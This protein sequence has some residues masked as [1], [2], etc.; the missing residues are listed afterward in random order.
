MDSRMGAFVTLRSGGALRGCI[1]SFTPA[2]TLSETVVRMAAAAAVED[3][4]FPPVTAREVPVVTIEISVL[5]PMTPCPAGDVVAGLH[6]VYVRSGAR[7]GT[8][9]PQVARE[10]GWTA[11]ELLSHACL[12]A[13]LAPGSWRD[14]RVEIFTYTAEVFGE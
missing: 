3:P 6:G 8:L 5:G 10:E 13:G 14:G 12:K 7:A 9:L 11:G 4:R 2:G 1:G